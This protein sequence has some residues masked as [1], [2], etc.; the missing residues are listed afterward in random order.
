M[1]PRPPMRDAFGREVPRSS[2]YRELR[3]LGWTRIEIDAALVSGL[4][5]HARRDVYLW[6]GAT[7]RQRDAARIGGRVDCLALLAE[8]G[9]FVLDPPALH[10]QVAPRASRLRS[11]ADRGTQFAPA[12]KDSGTRI[13]WRTS[14][15]ERDALVVPVVEA[16]AQSFRC[17]GLRAAIASIDSALHLGLIAAHDLDLLFGLVPERFRKL[18]GLIDGRAES[19]PETFARLLART[20]GLP[21]E[22]QKSIPGVG[23]VD[24]VLDGWLVIECDS[25]EFHSSWEAQQ[26]DHRRDMALAALGYA[27]IRVTANQLFTQPRILLDAIRGLLA[28]RATA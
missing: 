15:A 4:L 19:G 20:F 7:Q 10:V 22:V 13:H 18:R 5:F 3:E 21:L 16:L 26:A 27:R 25:R 8:L 23:R 9:V 11:S 28:T 14:A 17:Q 24:L 2:S 6:R 12:S 1:D